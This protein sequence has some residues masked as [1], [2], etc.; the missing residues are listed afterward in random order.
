MLQSLIKNKYIALSCISMASI[1]K[2]WRK[3]NNE[4]TSKD[5]NKDLGGD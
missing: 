5:R 4:K 3:N 2:Q 1:T